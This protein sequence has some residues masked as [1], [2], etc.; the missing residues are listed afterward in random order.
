MK[1]WLDDVRPAPSGW[2]HIKT[3]DELKYLLE[4]D[5]P[6]P[7]IEAMSFDHDL[8]EGEPTGY[9]I[10]KWLADQC[11][12]RET[13]KFWPKRIYVHSANPVGAQNIRA[14]EKFFFEKYIS[15]L[16]E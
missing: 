8:G 12:S 16:G 4:S 9:D 13:R 7:E 5:M 14:F 6:S 15:E 2:V 10:I 1:I 11:V 3:L